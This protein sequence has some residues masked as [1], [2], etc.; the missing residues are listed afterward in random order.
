MPAR[1]QLGRKFWPPR[2]GALLMGMRVA[3][4]AGCLL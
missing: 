3:A 1:R 4:A 2:I